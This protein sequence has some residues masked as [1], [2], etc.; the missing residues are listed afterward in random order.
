[1]SLSTWLQQ[2]ANG[3]PR[4]TIRSARRPD[5]SIRSKIALLLEALE[6]RLAPA[7]ILDWTGADAHIDLTTTG[8]QG[9]Y[10]KLT[11]TA[12]QTVPANLTNPNWLGSPLQQ[13]PAVTSPLTGTINFASIGTS[14]FISQDG[15]TSVVTRVTNTEARWFGFIDIPAATGGGTA[16][17]AVSF[18]TRSDDTSD[19]YVDGALAVNNNFYQ[20][21]TTRGVTINLAPGLHTIDIEYARAAAAPA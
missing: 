7:N 6:D 17:H 9:Q 16:A 11:S 2:L 5:G 1:M 10:F 20:G 21:T 13:P 18:R 14:S 19:I 4:K 12:N 15:A 3:S 8:L